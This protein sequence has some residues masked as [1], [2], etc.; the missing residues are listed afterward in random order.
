MSPRLWSYY[1]RMRLVFRRR[2]TGKYLSLIMTRMTVPGITGQRLL[3]GLYFGVTIFLGLFDKRS[4]HICFFTGRH[5]DTMTS[6]F[7]T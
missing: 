1:L 4:R 6:F 7:I 2:I 5:K 3:L